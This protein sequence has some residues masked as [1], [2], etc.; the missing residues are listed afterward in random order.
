MFLHFAPRGQRVGV[1]GCVKAWPQHNPAHTGTSIFVSML[2]LKVV[3]HKSF[4]RTWKDDVF[5]YDCKSNESSLTS[6]TA[7]VS[8]L[9]VERW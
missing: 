1:H 6:V 9:G 4:L 8:L 7:F 5:E 3:L 2:Q